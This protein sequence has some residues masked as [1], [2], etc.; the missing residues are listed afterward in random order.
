R[1]VTH[2]LTR[3]ETALAA[4]EA[5]RD[6][7]DEPGAVEGLVQLVHSPRTAKEATTAL[8][9]LAGRAEPIVLDALLAALDSPHSTVRLAALPAM[10]PPRAGK[11]CLPS[12]PPPPP[13]RL[14]A[15]PPR[16]PRC[17]G[18][19]PRLAARAVRRGRPA[20][21]RPPRP[22]PRPAAAGRKRR[23]SLRNGRP[24]A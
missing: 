12:R 21:A 6:H 17:P 8:A 4:A 2:A 23:I 5:L 13:R 11:Q 18:R 15:R 22:H 14:V 1:R 9:L 24:V 10:G 7:L 16:R 20:L 3:P 19:F